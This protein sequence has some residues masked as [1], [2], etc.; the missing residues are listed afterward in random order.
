MKIKLSQNA[1]PYLASCDS[2]KARFGV[3]DDSED[4]FATA[5][6]EDS[7]T[8][9]PNTNSQYPFDPKRFPP[10]AFA[11]VDNT[12][13]VVGASM[14]A[15]F[16]HAAHLCINSPLYSKAMEDLKIKLPSKRPFE[17][18][19]KELGVED[20]SNSFSDPEAQRVRGKKGGRNSLLSQWENALARMLERCSKVR[21]ELS[22]S[23][24]SFTDRCVLDLRGARKVGLRPLNRRGM[25][26]SPL[27][28]R[29]PTRFV[30]FLSNLLYRSVTDAA[31]PLASSTFTGP[32]EDSVNVNLGSG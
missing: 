23:R 1:K 5:I 30:A 24:V 14:E 21:F 12:P 32:V 16:I 22:F 10:K 19:N 3:P 2:S 17:V 6:E 18:R 29:V 15:L 9:E 11:Y 31:S 13:L 20:R 4:A 25:R 26:T 7:K 8:V 28:W 27:G